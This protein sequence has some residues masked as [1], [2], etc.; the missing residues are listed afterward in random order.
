VENRTEI[1]NWHPPTWGSLIFY[2]DFD[3]LAFALL[4]QGGL[5]IASYY[6]AVQALEKYLKA[7]ALSIADPV[8]TKRSHPTH[9]R[10]LN[11]HNLVALADLCAADYPY[12]KTAI[13][14]KAL[15]RFSDFDQAT[16]YPWVTK[17]MSSGFTGADVPILCELLLRLRND[18]PIVRDDYPLGMFIRGYHHNH[19]EEPTN[20]TW[21][22]IQAPALAAARAIIP[23]IEQMVRW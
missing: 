22:A 12:Y 11:S 1:D 9:K 13:A 15:V 16:R 23:K 2:A 7:L 8:G 17:P 6:H 14:R 5:F 10:L 4:F 18:I 20:A 3:V 21:I 19:P